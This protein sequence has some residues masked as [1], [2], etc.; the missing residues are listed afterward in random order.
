LDAAQHAPE[1]LRELQ[2]CFTTMHHSLLRDT[3]ALASDA[4]AQVVQG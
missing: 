3:P 4:I 1:R 2:D